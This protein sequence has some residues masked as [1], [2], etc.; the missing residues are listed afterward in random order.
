MAQVMNKSEKDKRWAEIRGLTASDPARAKTLAWAWFT[1][2]TSPALHQQLPWLFNQGE[3]PADAPNG[4]C[5]GVVMQLYGAPWLT[6]V[7][8]LV[9]LGQLLGRIGWTGKS[10]DTATH[11]GYNRLTSSSLIAMK[12][13]MPAYRFDRVGGEL[14]GFRFNYGI[15]TSP[16]SPGPRV[17]AIRYDDPAH[18]NPLVLPRTRDELVVIAPDVYLGRALLR[19]KNVWQVVGYFGLR[20][21]VEKGR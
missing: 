11:T 15:E 4:D 2:L 17:L 18:A 5:Q 6:G 10:F 13:A 1:E 19:V 20:Y 12:L 3:A 9:R 16:I 14:V 7:D 8:L 21:P